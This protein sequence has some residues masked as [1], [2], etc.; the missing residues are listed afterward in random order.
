MDQQTNISKNVIDRRKATTHGL[1]GFIGLVL[2]FFGGGLRPSAHGPD[3]ELVQTVSTALDRGQEFWSR[4][5]DAN[6]WRDARI[7]LIDEDEKTACGVVG[8]L[9]GPVYCPSAEKIYLD[10]S[11]LYAIEGQ[12]ARSYVIAHELGHHVQRV[13][14]ELAGRSSLDLELEADCLAG[15]WI[16]SEQDGGHLAAGD[17]DAALVEA[18]SVGDDRICPTCSSEQWTHGSSEQR[19]AS[20]RRGIGGDA[21]R[22]R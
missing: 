18:A 9:T 14:S 8:K 4:N 16:K 22:Q 6:H 10:L 7:V 11:F 2:G 5:S 1:A 13:R 15:R 20:V 19:I 21:C 12:L 17:I 3:A